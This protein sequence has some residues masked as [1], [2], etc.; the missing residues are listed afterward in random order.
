MK[1]SKPVYNAQLKYNDLDSVTKF[2]FDSLYDL[3]YEMSQSD[4]S[5]NFRVMNNGYL[6]LD[7][8]VDDNCRTLVFPTSTK[9]NMAR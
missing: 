1:K 4:N 7:L 2:L 3:Y 5:G 8:I 9:Y 6:A